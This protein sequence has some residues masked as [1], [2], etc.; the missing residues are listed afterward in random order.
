ML[1]APKLTPACRG[2]DKP[3]AARTRAEELHSL[4]DARD[5]RR[6]CVAFSNARIWVHITRSWCKLAVEWVRVLWR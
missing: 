6:D 1:D 4:P 2:R 3:V 5:R